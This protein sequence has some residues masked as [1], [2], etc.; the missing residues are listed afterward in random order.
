LVTCGEFIEFI[1]DGGYR[2]PEL[3]L[4]D[5]WDRVEQN[6]W[7]APLYWEKKEDAWWHFTLAGLRKIHRNQPV[8]H[9]SY[10][11]A[12]AFA[13]WSGNRLPTEAEWELAA[14]TVPLEGNFL[15]SGNLRPRVAKIQN[16]NNLHQ[17]FGDVWEWTQSPYTPYPRFRPQTGPLGE[18]NG[19]FMCN[20]MVLRGGSCFTPGDHIRVTYRNF[21]PPHSQWQMAGIR[22]AKDI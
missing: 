22:L 6:S 11:E 13:R 2:R 20:Q 5:G 14:Q 10:Y 16:Q 3:W 12:D 9:V 18:Y 4:S 17:L 21:Y 7:S 19:K 15:E 8:S 1:E